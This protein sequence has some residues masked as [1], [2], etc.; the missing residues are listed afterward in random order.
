MTWREKNVARKK[1]KLALAWTELV[2]STPALYSVYFGKLTIK[3]LH[4][5]EVV[6]WQS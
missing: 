4:K 1:C 2:N 3:I 6:V 5:L